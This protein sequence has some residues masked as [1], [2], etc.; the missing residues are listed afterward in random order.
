MISEKK[1]H[2]FHTRT[3]HC[4]TALSESLVRLHT[5]PFLLFRILTVKAKKNSFS[6]IHSKIK[7]KDRRAP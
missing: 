7:K 1:I 4:E 6:C 2:N 5:T 3:V